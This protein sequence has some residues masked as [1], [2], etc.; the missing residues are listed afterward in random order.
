MD[1]PR[2]V[3]TDGIPKL[4]VSGRYVYTCHQRGTENECEV[5]EAN[6]DG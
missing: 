1:H 3:E 6:R 4:V 5:S 2:I